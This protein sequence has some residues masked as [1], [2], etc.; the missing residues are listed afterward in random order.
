MGLAGWQPRAFLFI[1][2]D[3]T[4]VGSSEECL[5]IFSHEHKVVFT[6]VGISGMD[7]Y[8]VVYVLQDRFLVRLQRP[9]ITAL[10]TNTD[11]ATKDNCLRVGMDGV[12]LKPVLVEKMRSVLS[13]LLQ[14]GTLRKTRRATLEVPPHPYGRQGGG[15]ICGDRR[16][17]WAV[18]SM[19]CIG[20][21]S[22]VKREEYFVGSN[23]IC[24]V[25]V[26]METFPVNE[27][28]TSSRSAE[29]KNIIF[30]REDEVGVLQFPDFPRQLVSYH[31][32]LDV[33]REFCKVKT[34]VGGRWGNFVEHV[35]R[36]F[37]S[38]IAGF[39]EEHF[40]ML[41]YLEKEKLDRGL[42][43]SISYDGNVQGVL[44]EGRMW[45]DNV[46]WVNGNYLQRDDEEPMELLCR[47][48]KQSPTSKVKRKKSLLDTVAQEEAELEAVLIE[49]GISKKKRANSR[50][51]KKRRVEPSELIGTKVT[52][53]RPGE[54]DELKTVEERVMFA[55]RNG[56]EEMSK[57][58]ARL[59]KGICLGM[60][61]KKA[62]LEKGKTELE[63]KVA[64]LKAD[65]AKEGKRLEVL[66]ASQ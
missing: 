24:R 60:L 40:F 34:S 15:D 32:N 14:N 64:R 63:K 54:E 12:V 30:D 58:V 25:L 9:L 62:K 23:L 20:L 22:K 38:C 29:S 35:G 28:S 51:S 13:V 21:D 66:K 59:M 1:T 16:Y 42:D 47:T 17:C 41:A 26:D 11:K 50:R 65:L 4:A 10:T 3:V 53:N 49:V 43:E 6:D 19:Y 7:G 61:E 36:Q 56:E 52:E 45:N 18:S 8:E 55:T 37:R 31:L 46:I 57:I 33:F 27:A 2:D 5:R 39:G 48:V 44:K